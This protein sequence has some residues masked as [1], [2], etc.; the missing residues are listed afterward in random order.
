MTDGPNQRLIFGKPVVLQKWEE[1]LWQDFLEFVKN[2]KDKPLPAEALDDTRMGLRYLYGMNLNFE[3]A[4]NIITWR[5]TET[6]P[7]EPS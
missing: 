2:T 1:K 6:M 5:V 3:K 7:I 4:Y